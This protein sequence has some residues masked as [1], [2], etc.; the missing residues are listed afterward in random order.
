MAIRFS[1]IIIFSSVQ[2]SVV[3]A[4]GGGDIHFHIFATDAQRAIRTF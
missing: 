4:C 2:R 1:S 3:V